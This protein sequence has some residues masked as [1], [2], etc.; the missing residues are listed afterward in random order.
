MRA[1][2]EELKWIERSNLFRPAFAGELA[3]LRFTGDVHAL[4]EGTVFFPN[5][6]LL[7]ITAPMPQAQLLETRVL[8]LLHF[9]TVVASK[10]AR[11][12]LAAPG[13]G[14]I[15]F[16]LR[17]AHGAEAG[18]LA[19]RASYLAGFDGISTVRAAPRFGIPV[20]GT[21]AHSYV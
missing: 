20:C 15:D 7:R 4:A 5:E 16:G 13:K 6:P 1:G 8:N 3:R 14:L 9:Q 19:A 21:M 2:D 10:A 11:S 12:R 18:L 17:R